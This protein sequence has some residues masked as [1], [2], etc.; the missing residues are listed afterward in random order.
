MELDPSKIYREW[1]EESTT[2]SSWRPQQLSLPSEEAL[3]YPEVCNRLDRALHCIQMLTT[4][5]VERLCTCRSLVPYSVQFLVKAIYLTIYHQGHSEDRALRA[6]SVPLLSR[7]LC[8]AV[9]DPSLCAV[10]V[11]LDTDIPMGGRRA[12]ELAAL[13]LDPWCHLP[14]ELDSL[15]C[16]VADA[17]EVLL[18]EVVGNM[19]RA[20]A[21]EPEDFYG[22]AIPLGTPKWASFGASAVQLSIEEICDTHRLLVKH[23]RHLAPEKYCIHL[24]FY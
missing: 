21:P 20:K 10:V 11:N 16:F 3:E 13:I 14:E 4:A 1:K 8:P 18:R 5:L 12:L 24:T 23:R 15:R 22:N 7:F 2:S 19:V 9:E 17:R 6:A